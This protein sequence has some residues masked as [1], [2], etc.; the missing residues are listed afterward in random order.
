MQ[1]DSCNC[2]VTKLETWLE[3]YG[4]PASYK[5][6]NKDLKPFNKLNLKQLIPK[7]IKRF[8]SPESTSFCHYV[9]KNN[10]IY[11]DCY[12]KHVGF[13]MFSDNILLSLTRK[14][15]LPDMELVINLGDWPLVQK[16]TEP[17]PVFSWCGNDDTIDVVMPTY[18]ITEST[19]ENMGR[20]GWF[21]II[22]N[23]FYPLFCQSSYLLFTN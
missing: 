20:L 8:H 11:R 10:K 3:N 18:D 9:T 21:F 2:P 4:C 12:G 13:N 6:I 16:G 1:P 5:K 17:L 7:I 22:K 15:V 23:I 19:L 14:V